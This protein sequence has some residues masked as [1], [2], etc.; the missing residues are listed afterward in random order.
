MPERVK[1]YLCGDKIPEGEEDEYMCHGCK[2]YICDEC[3]R[4]SS[5]PFGPHKPELHKSE[6]DCEW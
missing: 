4:N 5:M 3:D 6:E 1:C 2:Q